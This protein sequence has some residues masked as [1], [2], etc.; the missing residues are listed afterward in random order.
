MY[1]HAVSLINAG[2]ITEATVDKLIEIYG[3]KPSFRNG[4]WRTGERD[5]FSAQYAARR[6]DSGNARSIYNTLKINALTAK[7]AAKAGATYRDEL[8][9]AL[10]D[11]KL[12]WEKAFAATVINYCHSALGGLNAP[13]SSGITRD[14]IVSI[15]MHAYGEGVGFLSGLRAIPSSQRKITDAEIDELL[16][17]LRAPY[18]RTAQAQ[19]YLF[20]SEVP[21]TAERFRLDGR[22]ELGFGV[23]ERLA[24]IYGFSD[25]EIEGFRL[26][27]VAT[28]RRNQ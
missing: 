6:S 18:L 19:S 9:T 13:A 28:Q 15:A 16:N 26:N 8:N 11:F 3:A 7:A 20:L 17:L 2:N 5:R 10:G 12:N 23:I 4:E 27:W 21:S 24:A 22:N 1:N 14:S 25:T